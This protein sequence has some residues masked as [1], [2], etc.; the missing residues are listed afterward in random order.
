MQETHSR[1][2]SP[3]PLT[4]IES[5]LFKETHVQLELMSSQSSSSGKNVV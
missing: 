2:S 4:G 1:S 5:H 3:N